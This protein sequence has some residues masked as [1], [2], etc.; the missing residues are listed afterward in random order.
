MKTSYK[1]YGKSGYIS[2]VMVLTTG[3]VLMLTTLY[4]YRRA[5][6]ARDVQTKVQMRVDYSEKEDAILRSIVA[7]VPNRAMAA[8]KSGSNA[9]TSTRNSLRWRNIFSDALNMAN[10]R[11]SITTDVMDQIATPGLIMANVGDSVLTNTQ[12]VFHPINSTNTNADNTF[13]TSGLSASLGAGFPAPLQTSN[14]TTISRDRVYPIIATNKQYGSLAQGRVGLS[15]ASYPSF[16]LIPYP[17]INFGYGVPGE[18]FVA[19]RNWWAFEMDLAGA[20]R[21]LTKLSAPRRRFVLSIYE[22]P[23]QLA[24]SSSAFVAFGRHA[25]GED[26]ANVNIEGGVFAGKAVV[27]GSMNLSSLSSRRGMTLSSSSSIGGENFYNNPFAAGA[28]EAYQLTTGEFYP[29]S[30]ASE[31]G[32]VAFIPIQRGAE[33]FDRYAHTTESNTV[34]ETT[35]NNYSIGALQC[36]MSLDIT[37]VDSNGKPTEFRFRA[38]PNIDFRQPTVTGVNQ[39][40][41][42][43]Y[44]Q[45]ALEN[46]SYD[47]GNQVVDVAYGANGRFFYESGVRGVVSFNNARFGDPFVGQFK[48][49]YVRG[50]ASAPASIPFAFQQVS[51]LSEGSRWSVEVLPGRIAAFLQSVGASNTSEN[52]SISVNVDY[53][54]SG[55]NNPSFN[56]MEGGE[57]EEK[58]PN[59]VINNYGLI[60]RECADFTSFPKGFSLVSNLR[61]YIGD[62]FNVVPATPPADYT[63]PGNFYPPVSLF[64]PEKRFG[65]DTDPFAI[66]MAGQVGSL[67]SENSTN[68]V[69]LVDSKGASGKD[70]SGGELQVNLRAINHPA[71]LPP[72][73]M[74]NWLVLIEEM[75]REH[76]AQ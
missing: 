50:T 19:K 8:M 20:D 42:P 38:K 23:S 46:Q 43:G 47:F 68:P 31:S 12:Q 28:R 18:L 3:I 59:G 2:Y 9:S 34:S 35:W 40:L 39:P 55:L 60:I 70:F 63:L 75:R 71:A 7:T 24:I 13:V 66:S 65:V 57:Y 49:G 11:T 27:E 73:T 1:K 41:P 5:V 74:M 4:V 62:D 51:N 10:A 37:K 69:R 53:T 17:Q 76:S 29:V 72:V 25:S 54:T 14:S 45:C 61:A 64:V 26:W 33:F 48:A 21:A 52:H 32:R 67:A 16:N 56:P 22:I 58:L 44:T 6:N 36:A 15:T 30:L